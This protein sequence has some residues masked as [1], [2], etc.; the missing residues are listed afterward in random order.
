MFHPR[1][2]WSKCGNYF[3]RLMLSKQQFVPARFRL[4]QPHALL[5]SG[6]SHIAHN[7]SCFS[8]HN[9]IAAMTKLVNDNHNTKVHPIYIY[10]EKKKNRERERELGQRRFITLWKK[11]LFLRRDGEFWHTHHSIQSPDFQACHRSKKH[12]YKRRWQIWGKSRGSDKQVW[13]LKGA[14][15]IIH[16]GACLCKRVN[17]PC[18]PYPDKPWLTGMDHVSPHFQS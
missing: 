18:I 7:M 13:L 15:G 16:L 11:W 10:E 3:S 12:I 14:S 9:D 1:R 4:M 8:K 2:Q 5:D 17:N 6:F